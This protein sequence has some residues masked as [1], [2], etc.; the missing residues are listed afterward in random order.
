[1]LRFLRSPRPLGGWIGSVCHV[2]TAPHLPRARDPLTEPGRPVVNCD[3]PLRLLAAESD[4]VFARSLVQRD[5]TRLREVGGFA[6]V[7]VEVLPGHGHEGPVDPIL[8][9]KDYDPE[10]LVFLQKHL[11]SMIPS[12][13]LRS[14]Q[15]PEAQSVAERG[16][17][18]ACK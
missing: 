4:S 13:S 10:E 2:P 5:A 17:Q 9:E 11:P 15:L 14:V 16:R 6:D 3:R 8:A 12:S 18:A 7:E 1:M